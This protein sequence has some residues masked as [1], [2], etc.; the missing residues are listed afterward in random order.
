MYTAEVG[1]YLPDTVPTINR[2]L[3]PY[4][5]YTDLIDLTAASLANLDTG[6]K[7]F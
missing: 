1:R 2:I 5:I 4:K 6:P 7:P 3:Y